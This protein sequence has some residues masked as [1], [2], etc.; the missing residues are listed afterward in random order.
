M[1][2]LTQGHKKWYNPFWTDS[3][4]IEICTRFLVRED[5]GKLLGDQLSSE[6]LQELKEVLFNI[7]YPT[8][9]KRGE[10]K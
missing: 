4:N 1:L 7:I 8:Y 3:Q 6:T 5:V 2:Q 10:T 9:A